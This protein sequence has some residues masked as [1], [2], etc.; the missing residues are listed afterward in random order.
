MSNI[1]YSKEQELVISQGVG[2]CGMETELRNVYV[3]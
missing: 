3:A 2:V 1:Q